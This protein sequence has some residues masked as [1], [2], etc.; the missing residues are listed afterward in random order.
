[1]PAR[2]TWRSARRPANRPR[3][4]IEGLI[5]LFVNTL[6]LRGD[7]AGRP[8]CSSS[9]LRRAREAALVAY[10]HQEVPFESRGRGAAAGAR[11]GAA[12]ALPGDAGAAAGAAPGAAPAG[13]DLE[14]AAGRRR[15][16]QV[17]SHPDAGAATATPPRA[18][19]WSREYDA[20][21]VRRH[22]GTPPGGALRRRSWP[23]RWRRPAQPLSTS[24]R[25]SPP[26]SATSCWSRCRARGALPGTT[27][28][29]W[30]RGGQPGP[31]CFAAAGGAHARSR[32]GH[33][34][35]R[36]RAPDLRRA[37]PPRRAGAPRRAAS[38]RWASARSS[39]GAGLLLE[40]SPAMVAAVLAVLKAGAAYV[41]VD[42][43][44]P[45]RA[46][47]SYLLAD[48]GLRRPDRLTCRRRGLQCRLPWARLWP[49]ARCSCSVDGGTVAEPLGD[50]G[51]ASDRRD[52]DGRREQ[53]AAAAAATPA[54]APPRA[55]AYVIYTSGSTG[56]P[57]G[58]V[59]SHANVC[60]LLAATRDWLAPSP[61][62]VW[63]LFHSYAFDFLGVGDLGR[64]CCTA[65][66]WSSSRTRSAALAG[67]ASPRPASR[68]RGSRCSTRPVGVLS[69]WRS[70]W[71]DG[72]PPPPPATTPACRCGW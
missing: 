6:V 20:R 9:W 18:T 65:A 67:R 37:R 26:A 28:P 31:R 3:A 39:A 17:R 41:P 56:R 32:G 11:P 13:L 71:P 45:R 52:R 16:R 1:M 7:L 38:R 5:G 51:D 47:G 24:C 54:G 2:T 68:P 49:A 57:K 35:R 66:G 40:R 63:T 36:R 8:T 48:A 69:G 55:A 59:V 14:L 64:S 29:A 58:V 33:L 46:P 53:A 12:A 27:A 10:A 25:C 72:R 22:H 62:D 43:A 70:C 30:P 23:P 50:R 61:A 4:E 42:P 15:H 60:R 44:Y 34:P 19:C 21:A